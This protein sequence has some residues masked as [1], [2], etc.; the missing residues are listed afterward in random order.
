[1]KR[2]RKDVER[3]MKE[4]GSAWLNFQRIKC[5]Q[6]WLH[7][8]RSHVVLIG[9]AVHTAHFAIGSGTKLAIEDAID[10][11]R[12]FGQ[13]ADGPAETSASCPDSPSGP[14]PPMFTRSAVSRWGHTSG[15]TS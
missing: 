6:W 10:L 12:Q 11:A 8:G 9:D 3:R 7:N 13:A 2:Y 15:K 5:E 1:M 4:L 14:T